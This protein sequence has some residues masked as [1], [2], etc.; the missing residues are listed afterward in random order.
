M[1]QFLTAQQCNCVTK[2]VTVTYSLTGNQAPVK[3]AQ[4][5]H[6]ET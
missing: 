2:N 6:T 3:T 4:H 1:E 5:K